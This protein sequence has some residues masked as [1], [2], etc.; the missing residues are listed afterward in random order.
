MPKCFERM[1][2]DKVASP[3][4]WEPENFVL[5]DPKNAPKTGKPPYS[6]LCF[7]M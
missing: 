7:G 6:T 5:G 4:E 2:E 3:P 1:G